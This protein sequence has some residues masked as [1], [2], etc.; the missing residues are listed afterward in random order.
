MSR[1]N[2]AV[3]NWGVES[4]LQ[5]PQQSDYNQSTDN[6]IFGPQKHPLYILRFDGDESKDEAGW[7]VIKIPV[8]K[9]CTAQV[10]GGPIKFVSFVELQRGTLL[11]ACGQP[12]CCAAV[13]SA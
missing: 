2:P 7:Y 3:R 8:T 1:K 13:L 11:P 6:G 4:T 10:L 12:V 9:L 5:S